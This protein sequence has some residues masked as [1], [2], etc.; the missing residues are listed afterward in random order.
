MEGLATTEPNEEVTIYFMMPPVDLTNKSLK[1][2]ILKDNSYFQEIEL[3]GK[4]FEAGKAYRLT[5]NMGSEE[6][7]PLVI[8]VETAGTFYQNLRLSIDNE[9]GITSLKVTGSLNGTDIWVIRRMAGRNRDNTETIGQ[10]SYLDMSEANII[11]GGDYYYKDKDDETEYKT[12][13][14]TIGDYM[15][16]QCNLKTIK[17]PVNTTTIGM[18]SFHTNTSLQSVSIPNGVE[19]IGMAAFSF[20]TNLQSI[21]FPETVKDIDFYAFQD[22]DALLSVNI[23][24][25]VVNMPR[26]F[27]KCDKLQGIHLP[28]NDNFNVLSSVGTPIENCP[29]LECLTIPANISQIIGK[30]FEGTNI[31][32]LH[33][34]RTIPPYL[35]SGAIPSGTK[36]YVPK[37][38]ASSYETTSIWKEFSILGE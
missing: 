3:T 23:P 29:S 12:E 18:R 10:L 16:Y 25:S 7:N 19:Y 36:I 2:V 17:L 31:K 13:A 20:C 9:Y 30:P 4:K 37:D 8:N 15:F 1:A 38:C 14:N 28:E 24:N 27:I 34:K 26:A 33:V 22:C 6:E 35:E 21:E 5:A 32:E 11:S